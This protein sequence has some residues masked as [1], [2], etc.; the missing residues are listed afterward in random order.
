MEKQEKKGEIVIYKADSGPELQIKLE[1][2]TVW[3]TQAQIAELFGS[4]RSVITK[5]IRN[6]F[7]SS[8]LSQNSVCAIFAHTA[9]DGKTYRTQYYNLDAII[10]VGYRV[11]SKRATQFRIWATKHLRD[12]L[13]KGYIINEKR[14]REN[15]GAKMRELQQAH[16]LIQE[17]LE[18]RRL[19]G[20]EKELVNII[21]E[22]T[23]TWVILND[24]DAGKLKI[25]DVSKKQASYSTTNRSK[26]QSIGSGAGL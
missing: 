5:H 10:S 25:S 20:F 15:Q 22:Y 8:E 1:D 21:T 24:Y 11:N 13:L 17:A 18:T 14:L 26:I 7:K 2:D 9:A 23:N 12:F 19:E 6:I 4:D 3:L 16:K